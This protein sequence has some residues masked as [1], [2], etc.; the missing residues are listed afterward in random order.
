MKIC[1]H[2]DVVGA[3]DVL[4]VVGIDGDIDG[5]LYGSVLLQLGHRVRCGDGTQVAGQGQVAITLRG[6]SQG[7]GTGC[8]A[9]YATL[10]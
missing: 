7:V 4:D 6:R 1:R 9:A 8:I 2:A 10:M 3:V 5:R